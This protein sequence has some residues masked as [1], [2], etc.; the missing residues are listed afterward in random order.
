MTAK[1]VQSI[2]Q[3]K[4]A[5]FGNRECNMMSTFSVGKD[6][7]FCYAVLLDTASS[8]PPI[9]IFCTLLDPPHVQQQIKIHVYCKPPF[10]QDSLPLIA[11]KPAYSSS[12][13]HIHNYTHRQCTY[14]VT[15][16]HI[17]ATIVEVE[18]Q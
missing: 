14:N 10:L 12:I 1:K 18:K 17:R 13:R 6:L 8:C 9:F 7:N 4:K 16:R 5:V 3:K 2:D 15:L 11:R